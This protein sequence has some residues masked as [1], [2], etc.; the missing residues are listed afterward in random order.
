MHKHRLPVENE[1]ACWKLDVRS[2]SNDLPHK[3]TGRLASGFMADT[4][5]FSETQF[6]QTATA[7]LMHAAAEVTA[8]EEYFQNCTCAEKDRYA[9]I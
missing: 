7:G 5:S 3:P 8:A 6:M 9:D 4:K 1:R 2:D